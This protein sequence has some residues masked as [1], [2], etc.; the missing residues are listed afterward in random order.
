MSSTKE[1]E[2]V[3][4]KQIYSVSEIEPLDD[5]ILI[6]LPEVK[7]KIGR[8]IVNDKLAKEQASKQ[9]CEVLKV[10]KSWSALFPVETFTSIQVGDSIITDEIMA[11]SVTDYDYPNSVALIYRNDIK[12]KVNTSYRI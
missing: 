5:M 7:Q 3:K 2:T 8:I 12:F 6:K 1:N 9:Y 10:G 11:F 4:F